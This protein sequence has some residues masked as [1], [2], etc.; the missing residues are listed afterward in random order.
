MEGSLRSLTAKKA[1]I[2]SVGSFGERWYKMA[3]Q[4]GVEAD[5]FAVE[6]GRYTS[7]ETVDRALATGNYDLITVT[8]NET[9]SGI[10]NDCKSIGE[11]LKKYPDVVYCVDAV[12]SAIGMPIYTDDWGIDVLI[13]ST[14]KCL[15]LPPGMSYCT[16]SPKAAQRAPQ[17]KNRGYYFDLKMIHENVLKNYQYPST[18]SLSHMFA[19]DYK[20]DEIEEEGIEN[21]FARHTEMANIVRAWA[22]D[23]FA[24]FPVEE[25]ASD[26]LTCIENTRGIDVAGLCAKL[27][28]RGYEISN[29]YGNLAEK[30]MRIAHMGDLQVSDINDLLSVIDSILD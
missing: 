7:A 23:R 14:Q 4:N 29:G 26:T 11:V 25:Y 2:F 3:E 12:S 22:R 18:P 9:S 6:D 30:T 15:A 28:D 5:I 21:R 17:A 20:L 24:I 1:A 8:H 27:N 19:L 10:T 13:S 16:Y